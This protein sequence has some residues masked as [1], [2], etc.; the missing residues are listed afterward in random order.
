MQITQINGMELY[1]ILL[2]LYWINLTSTFGLYDQNTLL[3][4]TQC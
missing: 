1:S 3:L 4:R 2:L